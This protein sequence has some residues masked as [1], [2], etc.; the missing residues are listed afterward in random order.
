MGWNQKG[1]PKAVITWDGGME[2]VSKKIQQRFILS[3]S[4]TQKQQHRRRFYCKLN[5]HS[6]CFWLFS[7]GTQVS[8]IPMINGKSLKRAG[9]V[10][11][12]QTSAAIPCLHIHFYSF[13]LW[14]HTKRSV[15]LAGHLG[16]NLP[17]LL[18]RASLVAEHVLG[19]P[20]ST[21]QPS[22]SCRYAFHE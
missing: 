11:R 6:S 9:R 5:T 14:I 12:Q 7:A 8:L 15:T 21:I 4:T 20:S 10:R 3:P 17:S 16:T 13:L 18:V 19:W 22:P 1:L 2:T